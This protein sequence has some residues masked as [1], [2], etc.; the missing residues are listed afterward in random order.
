MDVYTH[1]V[2]VKSADVNE[3]PTSSL[4]QQREKEE[5]GNDQEGKDEE[6][7]SGDN[8]K[9]YTEKRGVCSETLEIA[10][11]LSIAQKNATSNHC[12]KCDITFKSK[13]KLR[14]HMIKNI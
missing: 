8:E 9:E 14:R 1:I 10:Y 11:D 2:E 6:E 13:K 3:L 4:K 5:N 12:E 7:N